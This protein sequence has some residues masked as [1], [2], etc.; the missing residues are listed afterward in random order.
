MTP[1]SAVRAVSLR[2]ALE[3]YRTETY[4]TE[5]YRTETYKTAPSLEC[6]GCGTN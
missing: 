5:T 4:R 6:P 1:L 2:L 3:T